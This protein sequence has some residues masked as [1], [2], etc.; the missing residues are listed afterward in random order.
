ME[1]DLRRIIVGTAPGLEDDV[2]TERSALARALGGANYWH[3]RAERLAKQL[4]DEVEHPRQIRRA[5]WFLGGAV[6]S[7]LVCGAIRWL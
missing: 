7:L 4:Q 6:F 2:A 1:T 5:L 3:A